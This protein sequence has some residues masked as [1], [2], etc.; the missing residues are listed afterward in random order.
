M[1]ALFVLN[2]QETKRHKIGCVLNE[3]FY[4]LIEQIH[5]DTGM[6]T[7]GIHSEQT[8]KLTVM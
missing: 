7:D 6:L 3:T 4:T 1:N 2:L 5:L 8:I